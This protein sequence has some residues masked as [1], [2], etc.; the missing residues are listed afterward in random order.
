M[1]LST[2][3]LRRTLYRMLDRVIDSGEPIVIQRRGRRLK[4]VL[5][6]E[7]GKLA[8]LPRR[9]R[10]LRGDAETIVHLDWSREWKP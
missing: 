4:I 6:P 8:K 3:E 1:T 7:A 2:T 9:S 10:A 5:V